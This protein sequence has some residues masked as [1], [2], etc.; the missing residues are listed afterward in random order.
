NTTAK[1]LKNGSRTRRLWNSFYR[2]C[3]RLDS[4]IS[5]IRLNN[6]QAPDKLGKP[7][8][9]LCAS[10]L[11]P[12]FGQL[13]TNRHYSHDSRIGPVVVNSEN[14]SASVKSTGQVLGKRRNRKWRA[15]IV[16]LRDY[17][18]TDA[19]RRTDRRENSPLFSI[20]GTSR[21]T[22]SATA[23]RCNY[24]EVF[25]HSLNPLCIG[26]SSPDDTQAWMP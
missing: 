15:L 16:R 22:E 3:A 4:R 26:I 10:S 23:P 13:V 20:V 14:D 21:A 9:S 2:V 1:M 12:I 7:R 19:P 25:R 11:D 24:F 6:T 8:S 5:R 18:T 17:P